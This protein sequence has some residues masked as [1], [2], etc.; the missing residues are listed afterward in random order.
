MKFVF[1]GLLPTPSCIPGCARPTDRHSP[2]PVLVRRRCKTN[3]SIWGTSVVQVSSPREVRSVLYIL[4]KLFLSSRLTNLRIGMYS[5]A[6]VLIFRPPEPKRACHET[7]D[8]PSIVGGMPIIIPHL[9]WR[10]I[11]LPV[12]PFLHRPHVLFWQICRGRDK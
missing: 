7:Q 2:F 10:A 8:S 11:G 3:M 6:V 4:L 9:F 1:A 5:R 12:L